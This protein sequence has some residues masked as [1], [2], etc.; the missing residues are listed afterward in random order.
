MAALPPIGWLGL[1][2]WFLIWVLAVENLFGAGTPLRGLGWLGGLRSM[3]LRPAPSVFQMPSVSTDTLVRWDPRATSSR[4]VFRGASARRGQ[5]QPYANLTLALTRLITV[6]NPSYVQILK[7]RILSITSFSL[8]RKGS[9][10]QYDMG[11]MGAPLSSPR[12]LKGD[13]LWPNELSQFVDH[14][15]RTITLVPDGFLLPGQNDG[16]LYA[17]PDRDQGPRRP[18]R[19]TS[20]KPGWFH[21][22]AVHVR[23]PGGEEGI[24][25]ARACKP[26]FGQGEGELVWLAMPPREEESWHSSLSVAEGEDDEDGGEGGGLDMDTALEAPWEETVLARGPD[27]MFEVVDL[28][29]SDD[30]VEVIAAHF[31]G[32]RLSVHSLRAVGKKP[33]IEVSELHSIE[34]EGRP[35]GLCLLPQ[36][37]SSPSSSAANGPGHVLVSTHECAYDVPSAVAMAFSALKGAYPQVRPGGS[38]DRGAEGWAEGGAGGALY[39]YELPSARS[40]AKEKKSWGRRTLFRGFKVRGWGGIFSPGAPGFPYVFNMPSRP[41][42]PPLILLAGDCTGSAYIF[43][44][45]D[46]AGAGAVAGAGAGG[47]EEAETSLAPYELAF[48][49]ECGATVGSAAVLPTDDASGD[50][51]IFVPS[52]ELNRVHAFRLSAD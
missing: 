28:D 5:V 10:V 52:Y 2:R 30:S 47:E 27:V 11:K 14:T 20:S 43:S 41:D 16:G 51:E 44:P 31:F 39:A 48:E 29:P 45:V 21:H 22:K 49:I 1:L 50:V 25:T 40:S 34:T 37:S 32:S 12:V 13:Y 33:F 36:Q 8:L 17:I 18:I 46:R 7:D 3:L 42:A 9:I 6:P 23:L 35:Y 15:G 38:A 24:L 4:S 19:I 26:L